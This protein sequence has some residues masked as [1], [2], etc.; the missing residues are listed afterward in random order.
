MNANTIRHSGGRAQAPSN[1]VI[2]FPGRADG[3]SVEELH[4]S[5]LW[6]VRSD[7]KKFEQALRRYET[8]RRTLLAE[9]SLECARF[10]GGSAA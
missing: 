10:D 3:F 9:I 7:H 8:L 5:L 2:S 4:R 1:K 6:F